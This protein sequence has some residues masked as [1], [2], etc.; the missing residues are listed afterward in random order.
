[1]QMVMPPEVQ[2]MITMALA[3]VM[4]MS[5]IYLS[6]TIP[7][8][9]ILKLRMS[10]ASVI[11]SLCMCWTA[12]I[13]LFAPI[14]LVIPQEILENRWV[15]GL[16]MMLMLFVYAG[17]L[18]LFQPDSLHQLTVKNLKQAA[19]LKNSYLLDHHK[20]EW[21]VANK[22]KDNKRIEQ[23]DIEITKIQNE[24]KEIKR[25]FSSFKWV[26]SIFKRNDATEAG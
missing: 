1:M 7:A 10:W 6:L 22:N 25:T 5:L 24:R 16:F 3:G 26:H 8:K 20:K 2:I 12:K 17:F 4:I 23:L 18:Y 9:L 11:A 13:F 19:L 15:T 21:I 14:L